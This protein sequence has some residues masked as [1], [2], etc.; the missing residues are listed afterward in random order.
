MGKGAAA[1]ERCGVAGDYGQGLAGKQARCAGRWA[2]PGA[3]GQQL[4]STDGARQRE[5]PK[6]YMIVR[7]A[8]I[9]EQANL[10]PALPTDARCCT[11]CPM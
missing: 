2:D 11:P 8:T 7:D 6:V 9:R 10:D 1:L 5:A 3:A 4:G